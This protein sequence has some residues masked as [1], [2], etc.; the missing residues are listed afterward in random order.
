MMVRKRLLGGVAVTAAALAIGLI[1]F[2][3]SQAAQIPSPARATA[4]ARGWEGIVREAVRIQMDAGWV[5]DGELTYPLG[6]KGKLPTVVL[7]HGSGHNDMN[8]TL[9]PLVATFPPIAQA[10]NRQGFAVL[11]FNKRG[12]VDV[13]PKLSTDQAALYPARPYE[14]V[15]RDAAAAVRTAA[16]L[17]QVD[18]G[19]IFLLGHSE[20]TQVASNLVA[21]PA[22][23]GITKPAGVVEMGVVAGTPRE[24]FYYQAVGSTLGRLHEQFDFDGDG[25]LTRTEVSQGL[26]GQPAEV[27]A[28]LRE[29]LN[30][31]EVDANGDGKL[32]IDAE[33][34]PALEAAFDFSK[35]PHIPGLPKGLDAYMEDLGRFPSPARDLPRYAGPVLLLN[36]QSDVQTRVRGAIVT[37]AALAQSGDRDHTLITYPGMG[38]LMNLTS[39]YDAADGN[40][41]PAV[42]SDITAWLAKH[43]R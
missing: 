41:D 5:A 4:Q 37:D 1:P 43:R 20:G 24:V 39:E 14:Q 28:Q 2:T 35:F 18:P 31:T 25:A 40:P 19:R 12:V 11:R 7:L 33:I 21:A 36:G 26:L 22:K 3:E 17:P 10:I 15:L 29:L 8:Q 9:A 42:L 34:R 23:Y 30:S 32:S 6:A 27:A 16:K 13:G 38:H